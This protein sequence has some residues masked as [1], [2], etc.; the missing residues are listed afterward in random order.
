MSKKTVYYSDER[1]DDFAHSQIDVRPLGADYRYIRREWYWKL[2]S[3]ILYRV[4][5]QPLVFLMDKAIYLQCFRN[6]RVLRAIRGRG[7]YLY[8]NH[9]N[10][11]LDAYTPHILRYARRTFIVSGPEAFSI[12]GIRTILEMLGTIPISTDFRQNVQMKACVQERV[13][14]GNLVMIYPEA[15]IWPYYT[16]V[17]Q[18]GT[19]PYSFPATDGA[20]VCTLT[21]CYKKRL[22]GRRP[23]VVTYVDGPFYPDM[24]LPL[25]ERKK[26]LR[27]QCYE[28]MRRRAAENSTYAYWEYKKRA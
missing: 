26:K 25:G 5:A 9:T 8:A 20:P 19:A 12:R 28:T 7:A 10:G 27:D 13:R 17:R 22:I 6:R 23:R 4:I 18:T 15:H 2:A 3:F 1:N 21:Q 16:G 14:R 24:N 11:M